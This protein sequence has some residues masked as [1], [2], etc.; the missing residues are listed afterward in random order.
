[1]SFRALPSASKCQVIDLATRREPES[2]VLDIP[3]HVLDEIDT[4]ALRCERLAAEGHEVRFDE[5]PATGRVVASLCDLGG[6][7]VR[8]LPLRE[9]VCGD[10][11]GPQTAA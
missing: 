4:A 1:M 10:D 9:V 5:D 7:V 3:E 11:D 2:D 8:A 6:G